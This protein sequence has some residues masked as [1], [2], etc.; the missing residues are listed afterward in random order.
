MTNDKVSNRKTMPDSEEALHQLLQCNYKFV[1]THK[2]IQ[3]R[4]KLT[5]KVKDDSK[6]T[7]STI[8]F[9]KRGFWTEDEMASFELGL[10]LIG[11]NF[12]KI[13]HQHL[14]NK[15]IK[16]IVQFY[17]KERYSI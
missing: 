16:E 4:N 10:T 5:P 13:Q 8:I 6:V 2:R 11:K 1:Q 7:N 14:P 15:T 3:A 12:F 17:Y 9:Q